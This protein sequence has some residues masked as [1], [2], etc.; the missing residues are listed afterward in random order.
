MPDTGAT[1]TR[2]VSSTA[3]ESV[4]PPSSLIPAHAPHQ[5]PLVAFGLSPIQRVL[6][7]CCEPL[8]GDGGSRRYLRSLCVGAWTS[9]PP[10]LTGALARFFPVS[11]GLTSV[12][13]RSARDTLPAMQLP[14]GGSFRGCSHSI[15]FRLPRSLG[16]PI[17]PTAVALRHRAAG[18]FTPRNGP[19]V[20]L[21]NCGIATCLNRATG[22]AGLPP[23]RLRPCRPL[24][25]GRDAAR[26]AVGG[27]FPAPLFRSRDGFTVPP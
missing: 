27:G 6:A 18:P 1:R 11:V 17:A 3:S 8:L 12:L 7:G 20:S 9:T 2:A 24:Q 4:T 13:T 16:P 10:R 14:Q 25:S 19:E 5:T 23:A 21:G 26:A 22:T 15:K